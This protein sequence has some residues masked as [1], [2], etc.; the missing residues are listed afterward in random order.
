MSQGPPVGPL[1]VVGTPVQALVPEPPEPGV[2]PEPVAP[3]EPTAPPVEEA[4][5]SALLSEVILQPKHETPRIA[6]TET[7]VAKLIF[8][9]DRGVC[10]QVGIFVTVN[11][12]TAGA[13]SR[14]G[15]QGRWALIAPKNE[16]PRTA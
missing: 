14:C 6:A 8:R 13:R 11:A 7:L 5:P 1:V 15:A 9:M 3:P 4:A 12:S 10:P 16:S 2:P